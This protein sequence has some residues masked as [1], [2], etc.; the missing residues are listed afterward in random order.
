MRYLPIHI[1][2][3]NARIIVAGADAAAEAKLRTLLKT[4]AAI[5]VFAEGVGDEV[6]RWADQGR[7]QI[8][9]RA[10]TP[11][12]IP[13]ATLVYAATE[14][15]VLNSEIASWARQQGI[16][17]NAADQKDCCSFITPAI[18]DRSPVVVSIGTEG[19]APG[20]ARA[21]KADLEARLPKALGQLA[22]KVRELRGRLKAEMPNIAD[23][24]RLWARVFGGSLTE[25]LALDA[26]TVEARFQAAR[27][28][29][30]A[31]ARHVHI[32]G[33]GPGDAGLLTREAQRLLHAADVVIYDRLVGQDILDL[34]RREAE[35][36]YVGKDPAGESTRQE[37]INA[38]MVDRATQGLSV[39]RLKSGDPLV[40]GRADEEFDAL[41]LAG[42]PFTVVPGITAAAAAGAEIKASLTTRGVNTA[43]QLVTG[44]GADGFAEL[45]WSALARPDARAAIYMGV[46]AA[47]FIQ[48]RLML[49][50]ASPATPVTVV[51]NAS[52]PNRQV[53]ST[54][55]GRLPH[56]MAGSHI[57]GPAV[58]MLG[59]T[60]RGA[61]EAKKARA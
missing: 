16:P 27:A 41:D 59:Y 25:K 10:M 56:A 53:L 15:E 18:V 28:G 42:V 22:E 24:Q 39:V 40:F 37:A 57:Q 8:V 52:R 9:G 47:R 1:D 38:L 60:P 31:Q 7:I 36:L 21:L 29:A 5:T 43:M 30:D 44:H 26:E 13:G 12:D 2:T 50:G 32:V 55:L 46:R 4:E 3:Q 19:A 54:T 51:E 6:S 11:S 33:A 48:G 49:H 35:Y 34:A 14:D 23:R 61:V 45:D 58:L 17:V 20:L